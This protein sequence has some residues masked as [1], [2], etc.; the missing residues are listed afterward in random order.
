MSDEQNFPIKSE[1]NAGQALTGTIPS[2]DSPYSSPLRTRNPLQK[3]MRWEVGDSVTFSM[4][5]FF[6]PAREGDGQ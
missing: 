2:E 1:Y 4:K 6:A 5:P 3:G